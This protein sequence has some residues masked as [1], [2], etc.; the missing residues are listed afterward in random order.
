VLDVFSEIFVFASF[1]NCCFLN[2][3]NILVIS[4]LFKHFRT[5]ENCKNREFSEFCDF[6]ELFANNSQKLPFFA[7]F[8]FVSLGKYEKITN[9][10][11][12]KNDVHLVSSR[13]AKNSFRL[14]TRLEFW[15]KVRNAWP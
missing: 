13:L 5:R 6:R 8:V 4:E 11:N 10:N 7:I 3:G 9:K 15:K 1:G 12:E 2:F 14:K